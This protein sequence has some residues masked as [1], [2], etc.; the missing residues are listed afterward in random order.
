MD[1]SLL[2]SFVSA[3]E[4][5]DMK[6][7][8]IA[9]MRERSI[10]LAG[11]AGVTQLVYARLSMG[12]RKPRV[13]KE[14]TFSGDLAHS[15]DL[16]ARYILPIIVAGIAYTVAAAVPLYWTASNAFMIVQEL[17]MGRRFNETAT[18]DSTQT[19]GSVAV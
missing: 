2:Y 11:L 13:D 19:P 3:P 14:S 17:Y 9:D 1:S 18:D 8:N 7:L 6:F 15:F 5:V 12:P 10:I 4:S 16:Q